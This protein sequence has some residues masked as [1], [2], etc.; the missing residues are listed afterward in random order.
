[1]NTENLRPI[2]LSH[3]EATRNG[4]LG[5]IT[6]GK[7]RRERKIIADALRAELDKPFQ[8]GGALTKREYMA[9]RCVFNLEENVTPSDLRALADILG[10]LKQNVSV[11]GNG[12]TIVVRNEA[13]ADKTENISDI[14]E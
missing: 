6:S 1:M 9:A 3:E 2:Q 14:G 8:E 4:R 11:E 13:E 7:A 5:G 10:E 12:V